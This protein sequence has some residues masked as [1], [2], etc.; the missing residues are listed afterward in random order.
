[1]IDKKNLLFLIFIS[2]LIFSSKWITSYYLFTESV[3][4]KVIFESVTDGY[5]YF[6]LVKY[7][8]IF[9]FNNS[10]SP[11]FEKLDNIMIPFYSIFVHSFFHK[12]IGNF[13]FI[14]V[15]FLSIFLFLLI[16]SKIFNH[17]YSKEIS[18]LFAIITFVIPILFSIFPIGDLSYFRLIKDD[19]YSLRFP[20]PLITSLYLFIFLYFVISVEKVELFTKKNSFILGSILAATLSSFYYFFFL[21]VSILVLYIVYRYKYSFLKKIINNWNFLFILF[22]VFIILT[23]P[24]LVNMSFY[25]EDYTRRAAIINIDITQKKVLLMHYLK[26]YLKANL[27]KN[28]I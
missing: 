27:Y 12:L 17:F 19:I 6:P 9:D 25:E 21:Q 13:S 11:Y 3:S 24:V 1:M 15:E 7:L 4:A 22:L 16:L 2:F 14:F 5:Y 10:F 18:I 8:S 28:F 26:S 23:L 20:R